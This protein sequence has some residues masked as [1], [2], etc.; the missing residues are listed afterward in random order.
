MC[1]C[2]WVGGG[3]GGGEWTHREY[4]I[5]TIVLSDNL[6]TQNT[7]E[8]M[9]SHILGIKSG[10]GNCEVCATPLVTRPTARA[11]QIP[12]SSSSGLFPQLYPHPH[13]QVPATPSFTSLTPLP[14]RLQFPQVPQGGPPRIIRLFFPLRS[15]EKEEERICFCRAIP[16]RSKSFPFFV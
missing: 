14:P 3:G 8:R 7:A 16:Y 6:R 13:P 12:Y 9:T 2:V 10:R 4:C 1:V 11:I 5:Q 15:H